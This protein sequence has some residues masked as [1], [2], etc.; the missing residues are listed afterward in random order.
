MAEEQVLTPEKGI[1]QA[2][3]RKINKEK[4][5]IF[6]K[7]GV[8]SVYGFVFLLF[9]LLIYTASIFSTIFIFFYIISC[10][11]KVFILNSI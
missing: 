2:D 3:I 6:K 4:H 10:A 7:T 5:D 1:E 11:V 9:L 8:K